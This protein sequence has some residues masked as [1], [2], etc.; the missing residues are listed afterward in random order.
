MLYRCAGHHCWEEKITK[1][2]ARIPQHNIPA[3]IQAE[4][5]STLGCGEALGFHTFEVLLPTTFIYKVGS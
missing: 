5:L 3:H 1:E 4:L 2:V